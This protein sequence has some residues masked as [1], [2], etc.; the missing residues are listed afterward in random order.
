MNFFTSSKMP[1]GATSAF[2]TLLPKVKNPIFIK[3]YRPISLIRLQYKTV[4]KTLANQLAYVVNNI[5]N[6]EQSMFIVGC[7]IL[8]GPLILSEIIDWYKQFNEKMMIFKVD[9][10]K[11]CY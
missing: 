1:V 8:D 4:S 6:R 3:D 7:Q 10:E 9:F 2:I 5:V 11:A